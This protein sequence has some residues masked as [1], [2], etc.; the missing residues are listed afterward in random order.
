ML[1]NIFNVVRGRTAL[2]FGADFQMLQSPLHIYHGYWSPWESSVPNAALYAFT[3]S[4]E[5]VPRRPWYGTVLVV[6]LDD[7]AASQY[8]DFNVDDLAHIR[9]FFAM[10]R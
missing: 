9:A 8:T 2:L 3:V 10:Y 5:G 7:V 6:K 1:S 4:S